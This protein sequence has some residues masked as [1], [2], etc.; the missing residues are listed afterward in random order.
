MQLD[1]LIWETASPR[2]YKPKI[3]NESLALSETPKTGLLASRPKLFQISSC[4]TMTLCF[5]Q[6]RVTACIEKVEDILD[7]KYCT[8][9]V[10]QALQNEDYEKVLCKWHFSHL[11]S[12]GY[13]RQNK[14]ARSLNFSMFL[15]GLDRQ[16]FP[17]SY[18][19]YF[20]TLNFK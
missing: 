10:Q 5:F 15:T 19:Q 3:V 16:K 2:T 12:Y 6:S 8:D 4:L 20:L 11:Q 7:L 18:C 9:G 17:A 1:S 14:I 13:S